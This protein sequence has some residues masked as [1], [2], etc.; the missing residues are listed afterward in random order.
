VEFGADSAAEA[1]AKAEA[2]IAHLARVPGAPTHR[3]Y[4][5]TE[6]KA[7]WKIR[8]AGPRAASNAPGQP[9]RWEGWDDAAVAPDHFELRRAALTDP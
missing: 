1:T 6:A 4:T 8:E 5:S 3:L 2:L 7:V 9:P